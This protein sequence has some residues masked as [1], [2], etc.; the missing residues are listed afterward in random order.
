MSDFDW[1]DLTPLPVPRPARR[2]YLDL[3]TSRASGHPA[4][5]A[6]TITAEVLLTLA[7]LVGL[8]GIWQ[9]WW[10]DRVADAQQAAAV[11]ALPW[12]DPQVVTADP[13][14]PETVPTD[15]DAAQFEVATTIGVIRVPRFGD[16][17]VRPISEGVDKK[18]ILDTLGIGHWPGSAAPGQIGNYVLVGHRTTY[19]K[20][21]FQIADLVP[22]D[23]VIISTPTA[24]YTYKIT[25]SEVIR[26]NQVEVTEPVPHEPGVAP[27]KQMI[28]M[29]ACH[30]LYSAK[31]RYVAYGELHSWAP[32]VS[33]TT[34][35]SD[36]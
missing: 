35:E 32:K 24:T 36:A 18:T 12:A 9:F 19:G 1:D 6:L 28:T 11:A 7:A 4:P 8:Y 26:P 2:S 30:P 31:Q 5:G 17:Y 25:G 15:P 21:F 34:A 14:P 27:T 29:I 13:L 16:D 23:D 3:L 20:P 10:T 22:G 33:S